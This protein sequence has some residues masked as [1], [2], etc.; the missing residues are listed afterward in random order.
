MVVSFKICCCCGKL[1]QISPKLSNNA[2]TSVRSQ[3][4]SGSH[5]G[6][7]GMCG[8]HTTLFLSS[9][10]LLLIRGSSSPSSANKFRA[11]FMKLNGDQGHVGVSTQFVIGPRGSRWLGG[12]CDIHE[13]SLRGA[14]S[15]SLSG[16]GNQI[17][18]GSSSLF[19]LS[20]LVRK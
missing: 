14:C 6:D 4:A 12:V 5:E 2:S 8:L 13:S 1:A 9:P 10:S 3:D 16:V 18:S 11:T 7:A 17:I 19:G 15:F 20:I